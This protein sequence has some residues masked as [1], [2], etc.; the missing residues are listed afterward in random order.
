MTRPIWKLPSGAT[1]KFSEERTNKMTE[2]QDKLRD[3]YNQL[4]EEFPD[5]PIAGWA[6]PKNDIHVMIMG[7]EGHNRVLIL[8]Y[9]IAMLS[10]AMAEEISEASAQL[11]PM[12]ERKM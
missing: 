7:R 2:I 3:V 6:D 1:I 5:A 8:A 12:P 10:A 11:S 4:N 9:A